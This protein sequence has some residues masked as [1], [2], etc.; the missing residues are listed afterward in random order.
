MA[1]VCVTGGRDYDDRA[2][3]YFQL[4]MIQVEFRMDELWHG[5][6]KTGADRMANDWAMERGVFVRKFPANWSAFGKVAGPMRNRFMA[7]ARPDVV[8]AFRGNRGTRDM[9]NQA[10][11]RNIQ[12]IIIGDWL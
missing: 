1:R 7:D 10:K 9:V 5:D 6:A 4:D 2:T 11:A 3:L 8:V 12:T